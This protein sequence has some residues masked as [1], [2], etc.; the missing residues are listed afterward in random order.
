MP[1]A[2][3]TTWPSAL[4]IVVWRYAIWRAR[5]TTSPRTA[6]VVAGLGAAHR[7]VRDRDGGAALA[8]LERAVGGEVHRRVVH[9]R[10]DAAV[11]RADRVARRLGRDP[12]RLDPALAVALGS[13]PRAGRA[14]PSRRRRAPC[15]C[16]ARAWICGSQGPTPDRLGWVDPVSVHFAVSPIG[17]GVRH[18]HRRHRRR[19]PHP[20]RP[21]QRQARRTPTPSTS[22]RTRCARWSS[23]PASTRRWSRT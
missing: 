3:D 16:P 15:P 11:H 12:R 5:R 18:A 8:A 23:A 17:S 21:P 13:R 4:V 9:H 6:S 1:V 22:P 7:G 10:V 19:S 14:A 2:V 20:A